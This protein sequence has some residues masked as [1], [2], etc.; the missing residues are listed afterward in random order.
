MKINDFWGPKPSKIDLKEVKKQEKFNKIAVKTSTSNKDDQK[1]SP[2]PSR[3]GTWRP[4]RRTGHIDTGA[5]GVVFGALGPP[6]VT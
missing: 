6:K 3:K 1:Y 2:R 4:K 5:G